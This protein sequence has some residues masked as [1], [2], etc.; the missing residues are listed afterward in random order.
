MSSVVPGVAR[1]GRLRRRPAGARGDPGALGIGIGEGDRRRRRATKG[2]LGGGADRAPRSRRVARVRAVDLPSRAPHPGPQFVRGLRSEARHTVFLTDQDRHR[3]RRARAA[4]PPPG[5]G[6]RTRSAPP[7][8]PGSQT[9]P[10]YDFSANQAWLE[11]SLTTQDLLAHSRSLPGG[12][13]RA[14][15]A[16]APAPA[17]AARRRADRALGP[18]GYA[19]VAARLALAEALVVAFRRLRALPVA[20]PA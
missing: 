10:S 18:A 3:H 17:P 19:A 8:T 14:R 15:R 5:R 16:Q 12:R 6:S 1:S 4:P 20:S 13:A 7:R 2:R 11:L 9:S